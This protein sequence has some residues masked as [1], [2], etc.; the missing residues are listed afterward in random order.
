MNCKLISIIFVFLIGSGLSHAE[1]KVGM[2]IKGYP[3]KPEMIEFIGDGWWIYLDGPINSET[4]KEVES[5]LTKNKVP[6]MSMVV[7][8]SPGG[9]LVGGMELG[10]VF[11]KHG[12]LTDVGRHG[13][14]DHL[15]VQKGVCFSACTLAYLGGVFRYLHDGSRYGVHRFS[16]SEPNDA[17]VDIAQMASATIISYL[18]EMEIDPS[19]FNLST[20]AGKEEIYEPGRQ[21][22]EKLNVINNGYSQTKWTVESNDGVIYLKGERDSTHGIQKFII[23]CS[24]GKPILNIYIEPGGHQQELMNFPS[25][26]LIID[27]AK[28]P[29]QPVSKQFPQLFSAVYNLSRDHIRHLSVAEYVGV[30]IRSSDDAGIYLGFNFMPFT[31]GAK[32]LRGVI[33]ACPL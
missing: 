26:Q 12:I 8:N 27:G 24:E 16:S 31:E 7:I 22:L 33:N 4:P 18:R 25:H 29:V 32:K 1:D 10:H 30:T 20:V 21:I 3:P 14:G 5:Y 19:L 13:G 11:R 15:D 9:S 6:S 23:A 17:D 2:S 28:Y